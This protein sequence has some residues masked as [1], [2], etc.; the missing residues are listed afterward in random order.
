[1]HVPSG[2]PPFV[3]TSGLAPPIMLVDSGAPPITLFNEDGSLWAGGGAA[4]V[5]GAA[6]LTGETNGFATDFTHPVDAERVAVKTAGTVVASGLS[7]FTNAGTSSK[8]VYNAAGVLVNVAAGSLAVDYDPVTHAAKGLLCEPQ[9]TNLVLQSSAFD[10]APWTQSGT[11]PVTPNTTASPTGAMEADTIS[12]PADP[13]SSLYASV[14]ITAGANTLSIFAKTASGTK[15]FRLRLYDGAEYFSPNFTAT[16]TWQRFSFTATPPASVAGFFSI[17]TDS[18]GTAG[19]IIAYGAQLETGTAA[20]S[21]IPTAAA[22]VTRAADQVIVAPAS[23][24]YSAT[25]GSW[26][27]ETFHNSDQTNGRIIN[28]AAGVIAPLYQSGTSSNVTLFEGLALTRTLGTFTGVVHKSASAFASG[29][30]AI[31]ADGLAVVSDAGPTTNL[32]SP[33]AAINFGHGLGLNQMHGYI[34]KLRYLP[35]RPSN[36]ELVTMTT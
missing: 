20:T 32:L 13:S 18:G 28:Y 16:T 34:R 26:W 14:V 35:R 7:F 11:L 4:A 17:H 2:A 21:Y 5:G 24:N 15:Q 19:S 27:A 6:L 3:A 23:I 8:W 31:T 12:L 29:D 9:A 30:R 25:A 10:N 36:A 33:G 1:V 22:S